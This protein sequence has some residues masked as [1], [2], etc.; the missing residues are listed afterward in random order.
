MHGR[1]RGM[2][3]TRRLATVAA[4]LLVAIT[5]GSPS[6]SADDTPTDLAGGRIGLYPPMLEKAEDTPYL[7]PS[8][9]PGAVPSLSLQEAGE[10]VEQALRLASGAA[11][12]A[13]GCLPYSVHAF[14]RIEDE[15]ER[16]VVKDYIRFRQLWCADGVHDIT[17]SD[18]TCETFP[19][20]LYRPGAGRCWWSKGLWGGS[21][22]SFRTGA[23]YH[24]HLTARGVTL[25]P[26][27]VTIVLD[28]GAVWWGPGTEV[29]HD[30]RCAEPEGKPLTWNVTMCN[31][32]VT[33]DW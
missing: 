17:P 18:G 2:A 26:D 28:H 10:P 11:A 20:A 9:L 6:A 22:F 12:A 13:Q 32:Y 8:G 16:V 19:S 1:A 7:T 3:T 33:S 27:P 4:A 25:S 5:V 15:H 23:T 21:G 14:V 30:R 24:V 31:V 29:E